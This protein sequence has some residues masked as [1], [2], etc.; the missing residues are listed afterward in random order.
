MGKLVGQSPWVTILVSVAFAGACASG[1]VVF[2]EE[3]RGEKLWVPQESISI[4]HQEWVGDNFPSQSRAVRI[5]FTS[6]N[7]LTSEV[8]KEVIVKLSVL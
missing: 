7:V 2:T 1:L 5:L 3:T 8:L 4:K 6:S